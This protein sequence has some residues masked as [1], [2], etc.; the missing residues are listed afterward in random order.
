MRMR[1]FIVG[2]LLFLSACS[3]DGIDPSL[4]QSGDKHGGGG[5]GT[6]VVEGDGAYFARH[7]LPCTADD[8]CP[9]GLCLQSLANGVC[10]YPCT[11]EQ[12]CDQLGWKCLGVRYGG[13]NIVELCLP[14]QALLCMPCETDDDC[15]PKAGLF[16]TMDEESMQAP[17]LCTPLANQG[18]FCG[19]PCVAHSSCPSGYSCMP[20]SLEDD[21]L[22]GQCQPKF[23]QCVCNELGGK[24]GWTTNC[25]F[26]NEWGNCQGQTACPAAGAAVCS[27]VVP[28][29]DLCNGLDDNCDGITDD[30]GMVGQTCGKTKKGECD[31]GFIECIEEEE[32]C[33]GAIYPA[34]EV[35]DGLDNNCDMQIDE[36]YPEKG[37]ACG[38]NKGIC[39]PGKYSCK[40]GTLKCLDEIGPGEET[41][42]GLD[43]DCDSQTDEE[44]A[45][46]GEPCGEDEGEC[47]PGQ[48]QCVNGIWSC[49]GAVGPAMEV[50]NDKDDDCDGVTDFALC[51]KDPVLYFRF[52]EDGPLVV[53]YSGNGNDGVVNGEVAFAQPG[54]A[55]SAMGFGGKGEVKVNIQT[56]FA[57]Q[58]P[59]SME[60][61]VK[62]GLP[63]SPGE[64]QAV[65]T[66]VPEE[67]TGWEWALSLM[68]NLEPAFAVNTDQGYQS[69]AD[70]Q[71][72]PLG[73]WTHLGVVIGE[74]QVRLY[75][76]GK[77]VK[78]LA[79]A[80]PVATYSPFPFFVGSAGGK[81]VAW[82]SGAID[83]LIIYQGDIEFA[84]DDDGD[85]IPN[86]VDLCPS[87][88]DP[89]QVDCD[90]DGVGDACDTDTD[91]SDG[92]GIADG[93][94]N[95]PGKINPD[96]ADSDPGSPSGEFWDVD[97]F[98]TGP[99]G[100]DDWTCRN[101]TDPLVSQGS[102]FSGNFSAALPASWG[103]IFEVAPWCDGCPEGSCG[104]GLEA[105]Q[106]GGFSTKDYGYVCMAYQLLPASSVNML[107]LVAGKGWHSLTMTQTDLPCQYPRAGTWQPLVADNKWHHKCIDLDAQLDASL[108]AGDHQ[109]TGLIWHTAGYS[110]PQPPIAGSFEI[111]DFRVAKSPVVPWDQV[112]D[113]CDNC[114]A[115]YN[116]GQTDENGN[117]IGD[118][119]E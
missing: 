59:L 15:T 53:D 31:L 13:S 107:T 94:D 96:Q 100:S 92:D 35:C 48:T 7:A 76:N 8:E 3:G 37:Q 45:G 51:D 75:R 83:E 47:T 63:L 24:T 19:Y 89:A 20:Y 62:S 104:D 54:V 23:E 110:C 119:C 73:I 115:L 56:P 102:A 72:L 77:L 68:E 17:G 98:E 105:G 9:S 44:L 106:T 16:T 67:G 46:A 65:A 6:E 97:T 33:V 18:T 85:G 108:G 81:D 57:M 10:A 14:A 70:E 4:G 112:G 69:A 61:W 101:G 78:Q 12:G 32:V 103:R 82:F 34:D 64:V 117:G 30:G 116:P 43:N 27:A 87:N 90:G 80:M 71:Y 58:L 28:T 36:V 49:Q 41:C 99:G 1:I 91:D 86:V 113:A 38:S 84:L 118:A 66:K 88:P 74:N 21:S 95:C 60:L 42:D 11:P 111:D 5:E 39:K 2:F 93:C 114:P 55:G 79:A 22:I 25:G 50:C 26:D 40:T 109:V 52:D 29:E